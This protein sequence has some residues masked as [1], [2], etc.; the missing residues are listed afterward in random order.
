VRFHPRA[1]ARG[2]P[3]PEIY[4]DPM[5]SRFRMY[6]AE[7]R[8]YPFCRFLALLGAWGLMVASML[9]ALTIRTRHTN[10]FAPAIFLALAIM[11]LAA[12]LAARQI[13]ALREALPRWYFALLRTANRHERR[14]IAFAWLRIPRKMRWRLNGDQRAFMTWADTVRITVT[15]GAR[16]PDDPWSL[17]KWGD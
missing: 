17:W 13:P 10:S 9:D 7:R 16:D 3:A 14:R 1:Q 8:Y 12:S 5:L 15:Y 4:K 11:A 6:G 2:F